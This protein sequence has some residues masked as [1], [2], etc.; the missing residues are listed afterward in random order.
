MGASSSTSQLT[1][2]IS[3]SLEV[4]TSA[5]IQEN[6]QA[7][8]ENIQC[9]QR[10]ELQYQFCT[11]DHFK[12]CHG[13]GYIKYFGG[14]QAGARHCSEY[15]NSGR[16]ADQRSESCECERLQLDYSQLY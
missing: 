9:G 4:S 12:F 2:T 1:N 13:H 5:S 11:S 15:S 10:E 7:I 14:Q 8:N 16:I 3:S 6:E